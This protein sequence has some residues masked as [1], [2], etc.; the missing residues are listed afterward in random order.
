[1]KKEGVCAGGGGEENE[2]EKDKGGIDDGG[3][4]GAV[5]ES[6]IWGLGVGVDA[7]VN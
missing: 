6:V 3:L 2:G 5:N 7:D 1:L 4:K